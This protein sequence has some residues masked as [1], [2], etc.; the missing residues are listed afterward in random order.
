MGKVC[1]YT[2]HRPKKFPFQYNERHPDCIKLKSFIKAETEKTIQ[3]GYDLFVSG[4]AI[5]VDIWAAEAV[6]ELKETYPHIR[7]EAAIPLE[8]E[9]IGHCPS[10]QLR[11]DVAYWQR[12][13]SNCGQKLD[14]RVEE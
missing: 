13:C 9:L 5:G 6:L 4:M 14:W 10:C 12:Y 7:L 8:N 2:G 11:W 3:R 1:C